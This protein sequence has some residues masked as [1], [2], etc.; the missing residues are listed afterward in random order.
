[1]SKDSLRELKGIGEKTEKLFERVGVSSLNQLLHYYPREYDSFE[2]PVPPGAVRIN[3]KNSV[4]GTITKAPS[5]SGGG[6]RAVTVLNLEDET[7]RLQLIWFHMPFLRSTLKR[8]SRFVFRGKV[9]MKNNRPVMEHPEIYTMAA[10]QD[11]QGKL[12]PVYGLTAG[13]TNKTVSKAVAQLLAGKT[14]ESEYLPFEIRE[15]LGLAELNYAISTIHF[16]DSEEALLQARNRLVFDEFFFFM[17]ALAKT[18]EHT[19]QAENCFPARAVWKTEEVIENLPYRL[20]RGQLHV[21]NELERDLKGKTLMNRLIQGDV[22][23]GK[24]I[25]AFLAMIMMWENGYQSALMVPTEVLANQ[26]YEALCS[27]LED[28]GLTQVHPVLLKGSC[29]QKEKREIYEKIASGYGG[30]IIGTHALIQESVRYSKLGLVITDEQHR[31]GVR[32]RTMLT[33]KGAP[34]NVLVMSATPIPRTLAIILYGDLDI[35]VL[36][37]LPARRKPIKNCVVNTSYR[38]NA[39]RF[40]EKE[41]QAGHQVYVICPMVEP[42][43]EMN[44]EN[45]LEYSERLRQHFSE[46]VIIAPLHGR[47]KAAEKDAVMKAFAEN[48]IQILVSTTVVEV[49]VNVPNATVMMIENAERFGLAQLHQLRGRVGR[50]DAQSY[51]IFMQGDGREETSKR[52]DILNKSNDGFKIA[53][54]DLKLRGPGDLFGIRQSGEAGFRLADIYRDASYLKKAAE[55]VKALLHMDPQLELPQNRELNYALSAYMERQEEELSL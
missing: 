36:D 46:E 10:Y 38:P 19:L 15:S 33:E 45:V 23:S 32:Q 39:Y 11:M 40:M 37:E 18:R 55:T 26:H 41:I 17:L 22:G 50:G 44:C 48:E 16:P 34:P 12:L 7:G 43:E 21:W 13:L 8:G 5:V 3:E 35:S 24:T 2:K 51:C 4:Y 9:I 1:M 14:L 42:N 31:F 53:E 47:M 28:N 20:T 27:L 29:T 54:E 6:A 30:M 25:L 49:G 52:L